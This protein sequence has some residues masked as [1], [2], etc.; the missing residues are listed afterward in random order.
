MIEP[1][2]TWP[3]PYAVPQIDPFVGK[4]LEYQ[5][6]FCKCIPNNPLIHESLN[7]KCNQPNCFLI[8]RSLK[9]GKAYVYIVRM[10]QF[11]GHVS[12]A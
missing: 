7:P 11:I 10:W 3:I 12:V 5:I 8:C 1:Q 2:V 4:L 9:R 6:I